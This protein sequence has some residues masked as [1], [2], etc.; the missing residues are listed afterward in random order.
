M[1]IPFI[2]REKEKEILLKAFQSREPEMVAIVG[3]RRI[4]KTFLVRNAYGDEIDI[5]VSGIQNISNKGQVKNFTLQLK[6][7][8]KDAFIRRKTTDWLDTFQRTC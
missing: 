7:S 2:G 4:G 6:N 8:L 3:R 5:E 1:E